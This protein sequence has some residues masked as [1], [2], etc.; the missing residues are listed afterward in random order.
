MEDWLSVIQA[1]E[2]TNYHPE[3]IRELLREEK[4]IGRKFA[5]VWMVNRASLLAYVKNNKGKKR[6]PKT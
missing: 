6:G 4:V 1:A 5:S 3:R 2:L